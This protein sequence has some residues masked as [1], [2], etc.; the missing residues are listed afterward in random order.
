M[1]FKISKTQSPTALPT[2][3][4]V[5]VGSHCLAVSHPNDDDDDEDDDDEDDDDDEP[6]EPDETDDDYYHPDLT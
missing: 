3:F 6:D 2:K 1:V 4:L 5:Y